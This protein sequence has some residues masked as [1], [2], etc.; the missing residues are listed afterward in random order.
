MKPNRMWNEK[1]ENRRRQI[2][3]LLTLSRIDPEQPEVFRLDKTKGYTKDNAALARL[4][5]L[6]TICDEDFAE[7]YA[8]II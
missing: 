6:L 2:A 8:D 1:K 7:D 3:I 4:D 5:A